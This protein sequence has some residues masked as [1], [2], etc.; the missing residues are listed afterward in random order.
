[1]LCS[2]YVREVLN[3]L[4]VVDLVELVAGTGG[5]DGLDAQYIVPQTHRAALT[6]ASVYCLAIS[7][8]ARQFT[9]VKKCFE[10][11]GPSCKSE[12]SLLFPPPLSFCARA[13]MCV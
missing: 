6:K 2:S 3:A 4:A 5:K 11:H 12:F 8:G 1:M 10:Q 9:E 13:R 7:A